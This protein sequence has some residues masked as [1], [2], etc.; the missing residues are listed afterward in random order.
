MLVELRG[1]ISYGNA[2]KTK[3]NESFDN[4]VFFYIEAKLTPSIV[5]KL[6][7]KR[8]EHISKNKNYYRSEA[9]TFDSKNTVF[10]AKA[11]MSDSKIIIFEA[12]QTH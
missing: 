3:A 8:S 2:S 1:P 12:K 6:F 11:K 9:N 5:S 10:K 4:G 7:S